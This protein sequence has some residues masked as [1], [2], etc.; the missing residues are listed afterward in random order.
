MLSSRLDGGR[1]PLTGS[2]T[3]ERLDRRSRGITQMRGREK[4]SDVSLIYA[5]QPGSQPT[6]RNVQFQRSGE[7]KRSRALQPFL[8]PDAW[9]RKTGRAGSMIES[10]YH[11]FHGLGEALKEQRNLRIHFG[12]A[13]LVVVL[14]IA[15]KVDAAGWLA[16]S[17][18]IGFVISAELFNTAVE[19]LVDLSVNGEYRSKARKAKD[20]AA[21]AVLIASIV[22]V[23]VGAIVF[24]PRMA[25]L[26]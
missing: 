1:I 14:G 7:L 11:A 2:I 9:K 25:A 17:L 22:A 8:V 5:P 16:L 3:R 20:T 19:H 18:S 26:L 4:V 21:A 6:E 23:I 13:V 12:A 10:F 24:L 15:L